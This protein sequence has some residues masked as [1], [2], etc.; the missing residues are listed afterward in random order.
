LYWAKTN[1]RAWN[2]AR[3]VTIKASSIIT[4]SMCH[5]SLPYSSSSLDSLSCAF[6]K[7]AEL[8]RKPTHM[9]VCSRYV[10]LFMHWMDCKRNCSN[11]VVLVNGRLWSNTKCTHVWRGGEDFRVQAKFY[12]APISN[13]T[14][15]QA[16][17]PSQRRDCWPSP[18]QMGTLHVLQ[19]HIL[20]FCLMSTYPP[21]IAHHPLH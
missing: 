5:L 4:W 16:A 2:R 19:S 18:T 11:L 21:I 6:C 8:E 1:D 9:Y 15:A 17:K 12:N 13:A 7:P 3:V 20:S 14:R 10:L